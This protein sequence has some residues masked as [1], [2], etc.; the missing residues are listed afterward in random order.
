MF[1]AATI[2]ES[3][4][5]GLGLA[6]GCLL[7]S[8]AYCALFLALSLVTRR[9]VLLGPLYIMI[10]EG[11]LTNL[12]T[13]TQVLSIQQYALAVAD[14]ISQTELLV[15]NVS[16]AVALAMSTVFTV[17]GMVLAIDRLRSFSMAGE[18]S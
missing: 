7:G 13:G 14:R 1:I 16:I 15:G 2:T 17:G 8:V 6:M 18:T 9:P 5:L 4:R 3:W 11:L 10:W 12:V